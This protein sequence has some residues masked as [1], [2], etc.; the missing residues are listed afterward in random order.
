[1]SLRLRP[2]LIA[3][4]VA[5]VALGAAAVF[6]SRAWNPRGPEPAQH[7]GTAACA[8]CHAAEH[9]AWKGS[10][11]DLAM[12]EAGDSTVLGDFGGSEFRYAGVVTRFFRRDGRYVVNTDGPDGKNADCEVRYTFGVD[13][14]QQYLLELPGGRLQALS[15]AWDTR[16]EERGGQRWFHL[17]PG[18]RVTHTDVLHWTRRSQNW[19]HMCAECHS[20]DLRKNYDAASLTYA[21]RFAEIDVACEACHGPGSRH[22]AWAKRGPGW[23]STPEKGLVVALDER[24]GVTWNPEADGTAARSAPRTTAREIEMCAR[25]HSRR[26][27]IAAESVPGQPLLDTH[28]PSLLEQGLY[29]ADGQIQGEVYEYGSFLQSRM[30]SGG[31]TCSDCHDPHRLSLRSAGDEMCAGCHEPARFA[32]PEHHRHPPG[33]AGA[34]CIGCHMPQ[35]TYMEV[36]PRRDHSFRVPRPDLSVTLG[37]S[38]ACSDCH[39]DRTPAWAAARVREW[40]GRDAKGFQAFAPALAAAHRSEGAAGPMLVTGVGDPAWP[41]IARATAAEAL[42]GSSGNLSRQALA[43]ALRDRDPL[44]RLGALSGLEGVPMD[45][46]WSLAHHL[47]GDSL[48]AL[49][50]QA[51]GVL[52]GGAPGLLPSEREDLERAARDFRSAQEQNADQPEAHVNLG[53]FAAERGDV[54]TAET[55]YRAALA[56]DPDWI[57]TYVNLA[58]LLRGANREAEAAAVLRDGLARAPK[59][60]SLHHA[61]GLWYVR[62][63]DLGGAIGSLRRAVELDPATPRFAYVYGVALLTLGRRAEA[64]QAVQSALA[65]APGEPSL[66]E[67][68]RQIEIN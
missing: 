38:N 35:R 40:L 17:Y 48:L 28:L 33:S 31:V 26:S 12:Q 4:V 25:C 19:N 10:D 1:V 36:D 46:R 9:T 47:L 58:D 5:I 41:A 30:H 34:S 32:T 49:R 39:R 65:R 63:G 11:H 14:L 44:V 8:G 13:P 21:T 60:A 51:A 29:Q 37:V 6:R 20:T 18:E 67:L 68:Q 2:F 61:L 56:I 16:P 22:V 3:A 24:H 43:A 15:I 42:A 50:V 23:K 45:Q 52:G 54:T 57:P 59:E 53:N 62:A 64:R 66:V 55:E 27:R 7:V